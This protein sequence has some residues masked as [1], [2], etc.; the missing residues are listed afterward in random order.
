VQLESGERVGVHADNLVHTQRQDESIQK[1]LQ[2]LAEGKQRILRKKPSGTPLVTKQDEAEFVPPAKRHRTEELRRKPAAAANLGRVPK[3][4]EEEK[5]KT[6]RFGRG[7]KKGEEE[8]KA[9]RFGRGLK[10]GEEKKKA[11]RSG[12]RVKKVEEDEKKKDRRGAKIDGPKNTV[13]DVRKK[14]AADSR[15]D[16]DDVVVV[17]SDPTPDK[18]KARKRRFMA[19][20]KPAGVVAAAAASRR[21]GAPLRDAGRR[22]RRRPTVAKAA[23]T[24]AAAEQAAGQKSSD[25]GTSKALSSDASGSGRGGP[26]PAAPAPRL[27]PRRASWEEDPVLSAYG[28]RVRKRPAAMESSDVEE[29]IAGGLEELTTAAAE[30]EEEVRQRWEQEQAEKNVIKYAAARRPRAAVGDRRQQRPAA[31]MRGA[32]PAPAPAAP[33]RLPRR[34]RSPMID[35]EGPLERKRR[36]QRELYH[37]RMEAGLGRV[38]RKP[39]DGPVEPAPPPPQPTR[40]RAPAPAPEPEEEEESKLERSRRMQRE[41]Y[42]RRRAAGFV[43]KR[44][45]PK[46]PSVR[47]PR[48]PAVPI[49][50]EDAEQRRRRIARERY[51]ERKLAGRGRY[52]SQRWAVSEAAAGAGLDRAAAGERAD[53][54]LRPGRTQSPVRGD[55][56]RPA[57]S[58][59][60]EAGTAARGCPATAAAGSRAQETTRELDAPLP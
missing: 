48:Y 53:G 57:A 43:R 2:R 24:K 9:A 42:A 51:Q 55:G 47:R 59:R 40:I 25:K 26:P 37:A 16:D 45:P 19:R 22:P 21:G 56:G 3:K 4:G 5:R 49:E 38:N 18:A 13:A 20:K 27:A 41:R 10:K 29:G 14:G 28:R 7:L 44:P 32:A 30:D 46:E 12:R 15:E 39:D 34:A 17:D 6:A 33:A 60:P 1:T 23:M 11:S 54:R 52:P 35:G 36:M 58:T 50:E 8:K 31:R